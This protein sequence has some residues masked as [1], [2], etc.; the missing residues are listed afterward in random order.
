MDNMF[1]RAKNA[2][3]KN[4]LKCVMQ[5]VTCNQDEEMVTNVISIY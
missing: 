5:N 3:L 4:E 2:K 1:F